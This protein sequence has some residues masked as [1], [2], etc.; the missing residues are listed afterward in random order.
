MEK[1]RISIREDVPEG[2]GP[3]AK[4]LREG[5]IVVNPDTRT[6]PDVEGGD[7]ERGYLFSEDE[8]EF[9]REVQRTSPWPWRG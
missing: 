1:L 8:L 2:R 7:A 5:R 3:T 4:A 6:N 9:L